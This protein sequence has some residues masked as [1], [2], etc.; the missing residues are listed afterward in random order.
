LERRAATNRLSDLIL[1]IY[2]VGE[3]KIVYLRSRYSTC[4]PQSGGNPRASRE[5]AE[6]RAK[7]AP[8]V[9][10]A[11]S[12]AL[13]LAACSSASKL[14][15][16]NGKQRVA[17]NTPESISRYRDLVARHDEMRLEKSDLQRKYEALTQQV[18]ALK[19]YIVTHDKQSPVVAPSPGSSIEPPLPR[20]HSL[21]VRRPVQGGKAMQ[22]LAPDRILFRVNHA[23][24][25]TE[26]SPPE[27]MQAELLKAAKAAKVIT[28][29]GRT[30]ATQ[31]DDLEARIALGRAVHARTYLVENGVETSK[32]RLRFLAAGG[33]IAD[34][35]TAAGRALNRR[36][37]IEAVGVDV[38]ALETKVQAVLGGNL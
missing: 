5:R 33:F 27:D 11:V 31:A 9:A 35:S 21:P 13:A 25:H 36:V 24:G 4:K 2:Y 16:P 38:A 17:V 28:I 15:I 19:Q 1:A 6:G 10:A 8:T 37:E 32:I 3:R 7:G 18:E 34:D 30:D 20:P 12:V 14:V 26:F 22:V 23:V 29:R